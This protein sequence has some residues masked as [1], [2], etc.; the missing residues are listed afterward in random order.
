MAPAHSMPCYIQQPR[1]PDSIGR[2]YRGC[3]KS[4]I[5]GKTKTCYISHGMYFSPS[6]LTSFHFMMCEMT[7]DDEEKK[8]HDYLQ[9]AVT[10]ALLR[11]L[12]S[13]KGP[14][15]QGWYLIIRPV[16]TGSCIPSYVKPQSRISNVPPREEHL[17][18][19]REI[20]SCCI[21]ISFGP[22]FLPNCT[23]V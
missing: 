23:A 14:V 10:T 8:K 4:M 12:S 15:L 5:P 19:A 21:D 2:E 17:R 13:I 11:V 6:Q 3:L 7:A 9:P 22:C 16:R 18:P 20:L 1:C